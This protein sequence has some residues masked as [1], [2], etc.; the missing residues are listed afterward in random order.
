MDPGRVDDK[1]RL[2]ISK[3]HRWQIGLYSSRRGTL[4]G[5][6]DARRTAFLTRAGL[7][8]RMANR[9]LSKAKPR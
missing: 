9:A 4:R 2:K 7:S 8:L 3:G 6:Q 5:L 1:L